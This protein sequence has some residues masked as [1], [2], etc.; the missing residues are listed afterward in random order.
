[1][2]FT[3]RKVIIVVKVK[4]KNAEDRVKCKPCY[5]SAASVSCLME[6][7]VARSLLQKK[8]SDDDCRWLNLCQVS[9]FFLH[10][11]AASQRCG[12]L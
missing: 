11:Q 5:I 4:V 7:L 6:S 2:W 12:L 9:D 8:L 3:E 1:M 10:E